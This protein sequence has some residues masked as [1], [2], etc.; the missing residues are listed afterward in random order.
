MKLHQPHYSQSLIL[1]FVLFVCGGIV[2]AQVPI[3]SP[4]SSPSPVQ[5]PAQPTARPVRLNV[6]VTD[7]ADRFV[8]TLR[9]EDFRVEEDGAAQMITYFASEMSPVS[10]ALVVD[11]SNSL[12]GLMSYIVGGAG[13]LVKAN[14]PGDETM[15][16][17]F[18]NSDHISVVKDFTSD[19][20][21]LLN[22]LSRMYV[23]KGQT[24][25]IDAVYL[26]AVRVAE[27]RAGESGHRRA[28]VLLTDGEDRSSYYKLSELQK[29]LRK[30]EVQVFAIGFLQELDDQRRLIGKSPKEKAIK[31]LDTL[32]Q[33]T[34]GR[35]FYPTDPQELKEAITEISNQLRTQYVIG[36]QPANTSRD[37]KFRQVQVRLNESSGDAKRRVHTRSGYFAPGAKDK[38]KTQSK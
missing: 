36:Y 10:Y 24:A 32:T 13:S 11:N 25:V 17:R 16:V 21:G 29:L 26:T 3:A 7:E 8:A 1:G 22:L 30:I 23:G 2:P 5:M 9:Q 37:G 28:L 12:R 19:Q 38:G 14:R 34:G 33:E 18:V 6:I 20:A 27:H 4:Q 15:L 31:L 35:A